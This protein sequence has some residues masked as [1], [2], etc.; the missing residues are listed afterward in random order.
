MKFLT[1]ILCLIFATSGL[2]AEL[3]IKIKNVAESNGVIY[4]ALWQDESEWPDGTHTI[5]MRR[6][7]QAPETT[8]TIEVEEGTYAISVFHDLNG[9]AKMDRNLM[10]MPK[11]AWGVSNDVP[12]RFGPPEWEKMTFEVG[13]DGY[14]AELS[15][16]Q[17]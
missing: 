13:A 4:I 10:R 5:G 8:L 6:D 11:E 9:N 1:A 17:P 14:T 16:N 7:A 12:A 2:A 15:L 3:T